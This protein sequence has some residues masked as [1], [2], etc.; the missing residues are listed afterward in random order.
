MSLITE[1]PI[2]R[3]MTVPT[4]SGFP[5]SYPQQDHVQITRKRTKRLV[6][7]PHQESAQWP[8]CMLSSGED[9]KYN[10]EKKKKKKMLGLHLEKQDKGVRT[11]S[12]QSRAQESSPRKQTQPKS[13]PLLFK[14]NTW[15]SSLSLECSGTIT[16]LL[17]QIWKA[18]AI[19]FLKSLMTQHI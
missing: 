14:G 15:H 19:N 13:C 11:S 2:L 4:E 1:L 7:H 17:L 5:T 16:G 3:R 6:L 8:Y 10:Q 9:S 12:M 18:V